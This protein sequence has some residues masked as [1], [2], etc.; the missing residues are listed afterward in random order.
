MS[1]IEIA[2]R[3][4]NYSRR[5]GIDEMENKFHLPPFSTMHGCHAQNGI[6][7]DVVCWVIVSHVYLANAKIYQ[8]I[9]QHHLVVHHSSFC[10]SQATDCFLT[11]V[12]CEGH[13]SRLNYVLSSINNHRKNVQLP[14]SPEPITPRFAVIRFANLSWSP[15]LQYLRKNEDDVNLW[16]NIV[17]HTKQ[18]SHISKILIA[19]NM[20]TNCRNY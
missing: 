19:V 6:L 13:W 17:K 20:F 5:W 1:V 9:Y 10:K 12:T 8:P 11:S 15:T 4:R 14:L 2:L 18:T 3:R 16:R 7:S